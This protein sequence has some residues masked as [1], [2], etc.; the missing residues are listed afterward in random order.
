[1]TKMKFLLL[2]A[3]A[4]FTLPAWAGCN[5]VA[6]YISRD[7]VLYI[8]DKQCDSDKLIIS[9]S[10]RINSGDSHAA[11]LIEYPLD[12]ECTL[13]DDQKNISCH[14]KGRTPLAGAAYKLKIV[15]KVLKGEV[16]GEK[17]KKPEK[18][19]TGQYVCVAGCKKKGVPKKL[20]VP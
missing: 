1:M 16:C 6:E 14:P 11:D 20:Y 17:L 12:E 15:K 7:L 3:A 2:L 4:L 5:S 8:N 9:F 19:D 10:K 18:I 13:T